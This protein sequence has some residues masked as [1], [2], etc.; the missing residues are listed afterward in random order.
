MFG[1]ARMVREANR[2]RHEFEERW[3]SPNA[4]RPPATFDGPLPKVPAI[5]ALN[6]LANSARKQGGTAGD[7]NI[8][9][10]EVLREIDERQN[11]AAGVDAVV[12]RVRT[13][14]IRSV[15]GKLMRSYLAA[16]AVRAI[17][18]TAASGGR[19]EAYAVDYA[20]RQPKT[21]LRQ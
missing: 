1:Q 3:T 8:I 17:A 19:V 9:A 13:G 4:Y 6:S 5:F 20:A 11:Y 10:N 14:D 12:E 2:L 16:E 15:D 21:D 18:E 7:A